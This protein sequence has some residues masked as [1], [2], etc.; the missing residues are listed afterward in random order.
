M[1]LLFQKIKGSKKKI[2]NNKGFKDDMKIYDKAKK[3]I[4][5]LLSK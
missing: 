4:D 3:L 5:E 2:R 1:L